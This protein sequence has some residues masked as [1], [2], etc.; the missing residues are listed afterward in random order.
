MDDGLID[1]DIA[2]TIITGPATGAPEYAGI[3]PDDV[4]ATNTDNDAPGITVS[5]T[6]GLVTTEAGGADSFT[7]VLD[8]QP[9]ADVTIGISSSDLTEG[10]VSTTTLIFTTSTWDT[11]QTV[12]V[13]GVGDSLGDGDMGY[14]IVTAPATGA[15]EYAGIDA[16]DVAATNTDDGPGPILLSDDFN[17]ADSPTVGQ[18][19][20]E[21][22][23][24]GASVSVSGNGLFFED[25]S[26]ATNRP[27]VRRS[28]AAVS[29]GTVEWQFDFDWTRSGSE[30]T[31][32]LHMQM[33][34][35]SQMSD[36]EQATGVGI[37]LIWSRIDGA[38]E[39]LAHRNSGSSTALA[40]VSGAATVKVVA[41]LAAHTYD[42]YIDG[43]LIQAL[44]SFDKLVNLNTVRFFTHAL[45]E[46]N[47]SRR[48]FD[49]VR[50]QLNP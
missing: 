2:Y 21:V 4:S 17:R 41:D 37:N 39:T 35:G 8:T 38:H 34:D 3:N 50:I 32:R 44:V 33:G 12:T 14:A 19:W 26:D 24:S 16:D 47:F 15:A 28:F 48:A 43:T 42:V 46:K 30:G 31:Y 40:T 1:G 13:T 22:E 10:T 18:G 27:L 29:V 45:N 49:N 23:Q 6:S 25:T 36:N 20:V 9:T 11:P 5:P 7:V